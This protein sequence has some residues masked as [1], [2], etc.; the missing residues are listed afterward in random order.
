MKKFSPIIALLAVGNLSGGAF[1]AGHAL[2]DYALRYKIILCTGPSFGRKQ[3]LVETTAKDLALIPF[4]KIFVATNDPQNLDV[5]FNGIKPVC[6]L[7]KSRDKQL[8]CLNCIITALK[9]AVNDH[10][11]ADDDIILF[12]H[13]SVFIN[14]MN[15]IKKAIGKIIC[16]HD[17]VIKNWIG[18]EDRPDKTHIKDYCHTDSFFI[19]VSSARELFKNHAEIAEFVKGDYHFC[20]EYFTKHIVNKLSNPYKIDYHHS[21]WKDNELGFYH[22]PRYEEESGWYWDKSN[23]EQLYT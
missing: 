20:E 4:K 17:M 23:Y 19:K 6:I 22:L 9:S 3:L 12:K 13:E 21:S 8:D 14:D 18:F 2:I 15:L 1:N 7:F 11:C 5:T 16:G 10:D